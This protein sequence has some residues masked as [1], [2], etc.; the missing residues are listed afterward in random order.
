M[1]ANNFATYGSFNCTLNT[2]NMYSNPTNNTF[3]YG[4][5]DNSLS[6]GT[7]YGAGYTITSFYY[8]IFASSTVQFDVPPPN[9]ATTCTIFG[10]VY[11]EIQSLGSNA[12]KNGQW[13]YTAFC[14]ID[15]AFNLQ[16]SGAN[17]NLLN[18]Q[19]PLAF[20][21]GFRL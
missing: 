6:F 11:N 21:N 7:A 12:F 17:I 16:N 18:P 15:A 2:A 10:Y 5:S 8:N 13:I 3:A 9:T 14:P 20:T 1:S 4:N 19:Y